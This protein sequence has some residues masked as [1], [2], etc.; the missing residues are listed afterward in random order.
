MLPMK[1]DRNELIQAVALGAQRLTDRWKVV[2]RVAVVAGSGMSSSMPE[3]PELDRLELKNFVPIPEPSV[4]GHTTW[5]TL[6]EGPQSPVLFFLG[7]SHL[8]E[9][10]PPSDVCLPLAL[11]AA[12]GC[13][14]VL[15]TNA[16]GGLNPRLV[17]GDLQI[18][19]SLNNF[20][21]LQMHSENLHLSSLIDQEWSD[22]IVEASWEN[23]ISVR[24]GSYLQVLGPS[25]ETRAE[26]RMARHFQADVIG[27][28]TALEAK[29][30]A[31]SGM[32]VAVLSLVTNKL[33]DTSSVHLD[34]RDVLSVAHN[35]ASR[36]SVCIRI[37]IES[38]LG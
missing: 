33:S 9:G 17:A 5:V 25:Y 35:S 32:H 34:H 24:E 27:M 10:I 7:R 23:G 37:A 11:A 4:P 36:L 14:H 30:A 21:G 1:I 19:R 29:W 16:V 22:R 6:C 26:V 2:P 18:N 15:F 8:F 28:S 31:G 20:T 12:I 38:A 3:Y 13:T